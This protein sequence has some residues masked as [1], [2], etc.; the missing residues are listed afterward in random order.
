MIDMED[1][2]S[3]TNKIGL[4]DLSDRPIK[5]IFYSE[6]DAPDGS[7]ATVS[8]DECVHLGYF[9]SMIYLPEFSINF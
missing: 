6:C 1:V 8:Y 5:G 3:I 4:G 7:Y 2:K 9:G